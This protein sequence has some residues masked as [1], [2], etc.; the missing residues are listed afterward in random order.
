MLQ[1]LQST[2]SACLPLSHNGT[3]STLQ[4]VRSTSKNVSSRPLPKISQLHVR[5]R[6]ASQESS[7][8]P[9]TAATLD[10]S[11]F[12]KHSW[13]WNGYKT[14]YVT[15]GCGKPVV[16]V[17]GFGASSGHFRNQISYLSQQGYKV[18]AL[19]LLGFGSSEKPIID[20]S[21]ELWD[22]QIRDF[23]QEFIEESTPAVIMGNSVGSLATLMVA[24]KIPDRVSGIVL[25]NCAGGMNNKAI[26]DDWRIKLAM[27]LFLLIDWVLSQP[28]LA[29]RLFDNVRQTENLKKILEGVYP[30]NPNAVDDDLVAMLHGPSNDPGALETFV[31]VITGPPGKIS[32]VPFPLLLYILYFYVFIH[33]FCGNFHTC[34]TFF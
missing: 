21:M 6:A 30:R 29:R 14:A 32:S 31:S 34:F 23:M 3:R 24:S 1:S 2:R 4:Y 28:K 12:K 5:A 17:H 9:P 22:Q 10:L 8:T 25:F 16:L 13:Q 7:P 11:S 20:Y 33:F 18:Y 26:S 27:P 15:A 19:D